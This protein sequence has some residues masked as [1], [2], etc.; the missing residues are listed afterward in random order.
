MIPRNRPAPLIPDAVALQWANG[1]SQGRAGQATRFGPFVG[2]H[3]EVGKDGELDALLAELAWPTVDIKHQRPGGAEVVRHWDLSEE[4]HFLPIT[5][6]PVAP[7]VGA[8][9]ANGNAAKTAEAGIGLHWGRG[10]G[11]RSRLAV[12]GFVRALWEA[13]YRR[14]V[15][16]GVRSRMTDKLLAALLDHTRAAEAADALAQAATPGREVS[17]AELW[18]PLGAGAEEEFGKGDTATVSPLVSLHP[19]ELDADYLRRHWRSGEVYAEAVRLWP[20]IQAWAREYQ[21]SGGE[22]DESAE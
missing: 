5:A 14:P 21:V 17:P 6:G 22:R 2:F 1:K 10:Q 18:L 3:I 20:L 12:R 9:L 16:L 19:R 4:L 11:E 13:G 8:S 7:T 15:Q